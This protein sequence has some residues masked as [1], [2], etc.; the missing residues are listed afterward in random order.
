ME[1]Q[2]QIEKAIEFLED[3]HELFTQM[4]DYQQENNK[5]QENE[6]PEYND[7]IRQINGMEC[8]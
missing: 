4:L 1:A 3:K 7:Y 5:E 6:Q 8:L 2:T